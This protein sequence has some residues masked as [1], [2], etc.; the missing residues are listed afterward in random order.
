MGQQRVMRRA[1][2]ERALLEIV[3]AVR[4]SLDRNRY[5]AGY[6]PWGVRRPGFRPARSGAFRP[7]SD[8]QP[9]V[10]GAQRM[11]SPVRSVDETILALFQER[12]LLGSADPASAVGIP[13]RSVRRHLRRL[14][15]GGYVFSP[16]RGRYRITVAGEAA[17]APIGVPPSEIDAPP[18]DAETRPVYRLWPRRNRPE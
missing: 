1:L 10:G 7:G 4:A 11:T 2:R 12:G 18:S 17:M 16:E 8:A 6:A 5:G 15:R 14:I 3:G 9:A 13:E